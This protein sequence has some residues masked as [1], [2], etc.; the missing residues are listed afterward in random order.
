MRALMGWVLALSLVASPALAA[1]NGDADSTGTAT[2]NS[3]TSTAK[4]NSG[5]TPSATAKA[6]APSLESEIGDLRD[7][8]DS[9]ANQL[10][11]QNDQLQQEQKKLELLEQQLKA[12]STAG[13]SG[14]AAPASAAAVTA[15]APASTPV[16]TASAAMPTVPAASSSSA[17]A[18][19]AAAAPQQG[20]G[21]EPPSPLFFKIGSATFTPLGFID[22]TN[23]FRAPVI[24][25]G[26]GTNFGAVP[27]RIGANFPGAGLTEDRF[28]A[29]N[30]RLGIRV[31][32]DVAGGHAIGYLETDFLGNAAGTISVTSNSYTLRMRVFFIDYTRGKIEVLGGQDW[33][34]LTPNRVG[35]SPIPANIFFSQN[36]D[37]N[38]QLGLVWERTPQFRFV[39]HAAK[40]AAFGI[41]LENANQYL[42]GGNGS[43]TVSLPA[44]FV[45]T[46]GGAQQF[47]NGGSSNGTNIANVMP[48][49]VVKAAFDPMV[50]GRDFHFEASGLLKEFQA[51]TFIGSTSLTSGGTSLKSHATGGAVSANIN[52]E[53]FK[54]FHLIANSYWSDG[55]GQKIFGQAPDVIIGPQANGTSPFTISP[56]HSGSGIGGA[57]WQFMPKL[58]LFGYYGGVYISRDYVACGAAEC[59]WGIPTASATTAEGQNR[60]AQEGTVGFIPVFW[61]SPNYG[62]LQ[63]ITQYS[64]LSRNPWVWVPGS[65]KVAH[66]SMAWVDLRYV[67][68]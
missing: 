30:S 42:G 38:Y 17:A 34:M 49:I 65:P 67:L 3:A 43:G 4:D 40:D 51:E 20:N 54:N 10:E 15:N 50:S 16:V 2:S 21:G 1:G 22:L 63:L 48:D 28:S 62:T 8:I 60:Y 58:M 7:L 68:P 6:D 46:G 9:Q 45:N 18:P 11:K 32:A 26:I 53:L 33:S 35:I 52:L 12:S 47:D 56:V 55:G 14:T 25:S 31:D 41:S 61:R 39:Y 37:T 44:T 27:Y 13:N 64:Y 29:Q 59:G 5:S 23:V 24:G 36:M 57:E 19:S 66:A